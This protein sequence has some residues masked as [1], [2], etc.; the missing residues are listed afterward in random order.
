MNDEN[1]YF[2]TIN[3]TKDT[4]KL[5]SSPTHTS[6]TPMTP[7]TTVKAAPQLNE[8]EHLENDDDSS[9]GDI[10]DDKDHSFDWDDE[11]DIDKNKRIT[12]EIER[13]HTVKRIRGMYR[14]YCCWHYLSQFMKR[15]VIA[16]I[17]SSLFITVG[18]CVYIYVPHP[19]EEDLANPEFTNVRANIQVWM[20]WAAFMWHIAWVVTFLIEAVPIVV[21]KWVKFFRGRRSEKVKTYMEVIRI[22][23]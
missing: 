16:V 8:K 12:P 21:Y 18:V 19:S 22:F 1:S 11:D 5:I 14:K 9:E 2:T 17:G 20:F 23:I 15:V 13:H 6:T 3:I 10:D 4:E 7:G